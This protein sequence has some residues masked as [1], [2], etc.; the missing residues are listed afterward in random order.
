MTFHTT[1]RVPY[2]YRN[3]VMFHYRIFSFVRTYVGKV[4]NLT[5]S[6]S[7]TYY[8]RYWHLVPYRILGNGKQIWG[9]TIM[10]VNHYENVPCTIYHYV[11]YVPNTCK[12]IQDYCPLY[13]F[14]LLVV[15]QKKLLLSSTVLLVLYNTICK[16]QDFSNF[17]RIFLHTCVRT[18]DGLFFLTGTVQL[19]RYGTNQL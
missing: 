13:I 7:K 12:C 11:R 3:I 16:R 10:C 8:N 17:F 5:T 18:S 1:G 19:Y 4:L 15:I 6:T 2:Q 14:T 9:F